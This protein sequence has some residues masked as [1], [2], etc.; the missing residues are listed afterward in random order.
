MVDC[1]SYIWIMRVNGRKDSNHHN[2]EYNLINDAP[3]S[4]KIQKE[5]INKPPERPIAKI[6]PLIEL[7]GEQSLTL[8]YNNLKKRYEEVWVDLPYYL[9]EK[10]NY[11]QKDVKSLKSKYASD[12]KMFFLENKR[13]IDVPVV[14][15]PESFSFYSEQ[16]IYNSIKADF[17]KI[18]VRIRV[19]SVAMSQ[20]M[21]S[22]FKELIKSMR[23]EDPLLL[24]VFQFS[25]VEY[26]VFSNI[27]NMIEY[28][29][30]FNIRVYVLN[31]FETD[32]SDKPH[33][34]GPVITACYSLAG[35]GDF[36][37]E[38]RFRA[39]GGKGSPTRIIRYYDPQSYNLVPFKVTV[40][41]YRGAKER[42]LKSSYWSNI[43][44]NKSHLSECI[45]CNEVNKDMSNSGHGHR[46][47]KRFR[48][49]HYL[50]S[51]VNETAFQCSNAKT[52]EDLDPDGYNTIAKSVGISG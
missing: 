46:Y 22:S 1:L 17:K 19:P 27:K 9:A 31:A 16:N 23:S 2:M 50:F 49:L 12:R 21:F 8:F 43:S 6:I 20:Q 41:G 24:D 39:G 26:Q 51:I 42:L 34:Y 13:G 28:A 7:T 32:Q 5:L 11:Y 10:S 18:A 48:I 30:D 40:D 15:A 45:V 35:F 44:A 37:T 3:H 14:S 38:K 52:P 33:N 36:A 4:G 25:S 29:K 47:W